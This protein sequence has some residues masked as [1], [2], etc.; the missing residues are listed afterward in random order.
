MSARPIR[1]GRFLELPSRWNIREPVG[2]LQ[3]S[4]I[5]KLIR[6]DFLFAIFSQKSAK[7]AQYIAEYWMKFANSIT[8]CLVQWNEEILPIVIRSGSFSGEGITFQVAYLSTELER[9]RNW[10]C[11]SHREGKRMER[12]QGMLRVERV[13]DTY[14]RWCWERVEKACWL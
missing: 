12:T 14:K 8:Q 11:F 3:H 13:N 7:L 2:F 10:T 1:V 4:Q 6:L 9:I 5:I